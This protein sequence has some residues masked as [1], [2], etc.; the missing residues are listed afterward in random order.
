MQCIVTMQKTNNLS[1]TILVLC[2]CQNGQLKALNFNLNSNWI[3]KC[4]LFLMP[5]K[6]KLP[7]E[8]C[9]PQ[10][11]I[12]HR[13]LAPYNLWYIRGSHNGKSWGLK[14]QCLV[15]R[16]LAESRAWVE[17]MLEQQQCHW[18]SY[19]P[20]GPELIWEPPSD[21]LMGRGMQRHVSLFDH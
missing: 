15:L 13:V 11:C 19:P 9:T 8:D 3:Q 16:L 10:N 6:W 5:F 18:A 21:R 2:F 4:I 14:G 20:T 1:N 17:G 7:F 12:L